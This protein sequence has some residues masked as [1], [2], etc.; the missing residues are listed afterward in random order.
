MGTVNHRAGLL[1]FDFRYK[2]VRCRE[3]TKLRDTPANKKRLR[4]LLDRI[5]AEIVLDT[6]EYS[7]YFP[8]S[9][10]AARF[11]NRDLVRRDSLSRNAPNFRDFAAV[12]YAEKE[13]EWRNS[14]RLCQRQTLDKHLLPEFGDSAIDAIIKADILAFRG[15]LVKLDGLKGKKMSSSRINHIM[16]PLRMI[17]E[18]GADRYDFTPPFRN[19]KPLKVPRSD[20][21]P[22]TLDEV[23]Q[24]L[25]AVRL[26]FKTYYAVRFFAALR[27]AEIDGLKWSNVDFDRRQLLIREASV[28]G[29]TV[30][31]KNDGSWREVHMSEP[32][33]HALKDHYDF[34]S[35]FSFVFCNRHGRP[36]RHNDVTKKV[37][38]PL[39]RLVGLK[40]RCPYQTRH[41]AATLWL[42]A[43]ESP[44]WIAR[45][46]GHS[47]TEMLFK[48]YSRY[49]PNL[50]RQDGS[51]FEK[52]L[53]KEQPTSKK[54]MGS[55]IANSVPGP[56]NEAA[57]L[58]GL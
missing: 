57:K 36:L 25:S 50:T 21:D 54:D 34:T 13:P 46:M 6:F 23:W 44:E 18:E 32:V 16:T 2:G 12:W 19:I 31:V 9:G 48:V 45:Q 35:Q 28:N 40:K 17:L 55:N 20:V 5:E 39:L 7:A 42:A 4:T 52:L 1:F 27:T 38:Y 22:F 41:T 14:Y 24:I 53:Q 10:M 51:A 47:T 56:I 15:K 58:A 3:Y 43:G 33:Y 26:D 8:N 49:V 11:K 37:W 29:E 30:A